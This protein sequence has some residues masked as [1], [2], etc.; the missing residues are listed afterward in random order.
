MD[1]L[2]E[3]SIIWGLREVKL[4]KS[5][6]AKGGRDVNVI[7]TDAGDFVVKKFSVDINEDAVN[8]DTLA[9]SYLDEKIV[10]ISPHILKTKEDRLYAKIG[11]CYAYI[12]EYVSGRS[13]FET[14]EDEYRLGQASAILHSFEDYSIQACLQSSLGIDERNSNLQKLFT[15]YSFKAEYDKVIDALPDFTQHWQSF[16]HTDIGPH[17]AIISDHDGV[18]FVDFDN[19]GRGSVHV[20]IGYPLITQFVRIQENAQIHFNFENAQSFYKGYSSIRSLDEH[21]AELIFA[22]AVFMQLMYMPCYG[23]EAVNDMWKILTYA[24]R[25]KDKLLSAIL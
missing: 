13:A 15:E 22:G 12:M 23:K 24:L 18:M 14:P 10:K 8:R 25:Y 2:R 3:L 16:I 17:N 4:V 20:D 5:L 1:Y 19:A 6:P 9:L 11:D 21:D 7:K